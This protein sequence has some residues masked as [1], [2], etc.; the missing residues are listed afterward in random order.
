MGGKTKKV[1]RFQVEL[2]F[3]GLF[4]LFG[5]LMQRFDFIGPVEK[6]LKQEYL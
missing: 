6:P 4:Y 1:L 2:L 5:C 3:N